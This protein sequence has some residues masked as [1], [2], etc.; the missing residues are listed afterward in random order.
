MTFEPHLRPEIAKLLNDAAAAGLPGIADLDVDGARQ[1]MR[2]VSQVWWGPV[3]DIGSVGDRT[4]VVGDLGDEREIPIRIYRPSQGVLPIVVFFHG[5]GWVIGDLNTHDGPCRALA[6][7]ATCV[8]VSVGYRLAP[9]HR[10]PAAPRDCIETTSWVFAHADELGVDPRRLGVV[11]DSAGA[12]L[13]AVVA[14]HMPAGEEAI[15]CQTL[16]YPVTDLTINQFPYPEGYLLGV[17]DIEWYYD[18][19]VDAADRHDSLVSPLL[20]GSLL[21]LPPTHVITCEFDPLGPQGTEYARRLSAAGVGV[22]HEHF[23]GMIHG[24]AG[25]NAVTP[26]TGELWRSIAAHLTQSWSTAG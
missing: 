19:Y 3:G 16:I 1:Q 8:V 4:I 21:G 11:G 10:F 9:E 24:F 15:R 2:E 22:V 26:A 6:E 18:H 17:A 20:A 23:D 25:M 7:L 5:G 12:N 14:Q 13:A